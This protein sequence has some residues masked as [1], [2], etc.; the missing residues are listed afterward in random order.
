MHE[1]E[2]TPPAPRPAPQS[3]NTRRRLHPS[4][5][6]PPCQPSPP[7][8]ASSP[9]RRSPPPPPRSPP[10]A[11]CRRPRPTVP[12]RRGPVFRSG[13]TVED[14]VLEVLRPMLKQWLDANLTGIVERLV[15]RE[16]R[17]LTR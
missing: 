4:R 5:R 14:L 7:P 3:R 2:P 17:K 15:E 10:C 11:R 6:S 9:T 8:T 16:I 13:N 1:F 12:R